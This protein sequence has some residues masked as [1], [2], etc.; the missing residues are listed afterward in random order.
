MSVLA[1]CHQLTAT[2][3]SA[4]VHKFFVV[5]EN[6]VFV[7]LRDCQCVVREADLALK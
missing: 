5:A 4:V 7:E 2:A 3:W 6:P 1:I